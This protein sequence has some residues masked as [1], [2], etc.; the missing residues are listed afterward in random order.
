MKKPS[1]PKDIVA[2]DQSRAFRNV[3][4][5]ELAPDIHFEEKNT[6]SNGNIPRTKREKGERNRW[7]EVI[8]QEKYPAIFKQLLDTAMN[9]PNK[10]LRSIGKKFLLAIVE[11]NPNKKNHY[12]KLQLPPMNTMEDIKEN[13]KMIMD[14]ILDANIS[15]EEGNKIFSMIDQYRENYRE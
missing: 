4:A 2:V 10:E 12:I 15:L 5:K 1:K 6:L 14:N 8:G 7:M 11:H 13:E 9:H 3:L